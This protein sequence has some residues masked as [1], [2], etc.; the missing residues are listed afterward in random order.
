MPAIEP[1]RALGDADHPGKRL[2]MEDDQLD[3]TIA[4]L[5]RL[6]HG[7]LNLQD[8]E[9]PK[10]DHGMEGARRKLA[11]HGDA[12]APEQ[13]DGEIAMNTDMQRMLE[14]HH[15]QLEQCLK[16]FS[17]MMTHVRTSHASSM[18]AALHPA[19]PSRASPSPAPAALPARRPSTSGPNGLL[20]GNTSH[21]SIFAWNRSHTADKHQLTRHASADGA[22]SKLRPS[23]DRVEVK[24]LLQRSQVSRHVSADNIPANTVPSNPL[25][26]LPP[27]QPQQGDAAKQGKLGLTIESVQGSNSLSVSRPNSPNGTTAGLNENLSLPGGLDKPSLS[28]TE[29]PDASHN[30]QESWVDPGTLNE[31]ERAAALNKV[32]ND[33]ADPDDSRSLTNS[34]SKEKARMS[35]G[36]L[37]FHES[38]RRMSFTGRSGRRNSQAS[39]ASDALTGQAARSEEHHLFNMDIAQVLKSMVAETNSEEEAEARRWKR[40]TRN[41]TRGNLVV[42]MMDHAVHMVQGHHS[43]REQ[44]RPRGNAWAFYGILCGLVIVVDAIIIGVETDYIAADPNGES[45]ITFR[46]L[47]YV[48]NSWYFMEII[49][50]MCQR[51]RWTYFFVGP[52]YLWNWFDMGLIAAAMTDIF[53]EIAFGSGMYIGRV[54][55]TVRLFRAVRVLRLVRWL[56]ILREFQK[57]VLCLAS[58]LQTLLCSMALLAFVMFVFSIFFTQ[59]LP[60]YLESR[61]VDAS[62]ATWSD[63]EIKSAFGSVSKTMVSLF[64]AITAGRNWGEL[65]KMLEEINIFLFVVFLIFVGVAIFGLLNVVAAVFVESAMRATQHYRDLL[66]H[67]KLMRE[68]INVQHLK[69]IFRNIDVDNSGTITLEEMESFLNDDSLKL[70]EYFEALELNASDT[71]SLFLLL[72]RDGSGEVDIDEFCDGCMRLGGNAKSFDINC[73][74][75]EMKRSHKDMLKLVQKMF[76]GLHTLTRVQAST[77]DRM[78]KLARDVTRHIEKTSDAEPE[79]NGERSPRNA[80]SD[81]GGSSPRSRTS[82]I[83]RASRASRATDVMRISRNTEI[84]DVSPFRVSDDGLGSETLHSS[85]LAATGANGT[86]GVTSPSRSSQGPAAGALLRTGSVPMP[87]PTEAQVGMP[88]DQPP[89]LPGV[90]H[91]HAPEASFGR[92]RSVN[93]FSDSSSEGKDG[94]D[95]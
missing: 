31:S 61:V 15:N 47:G 71:V 59:S 89:K 51:E 63:Q 76:L 46:A 3:E 65:A 18:S 8:V 77:K 58:S 32:F 2:S 41:N 88:A 44:P 13:K 14:H 45:N 35:K 73:M 12:A 33:S 81:V 19:T 34:P 52:D 42:R 68:R 43:R 64:Q 69:E 56:Q 84:N 17:R 80:A 67:E 70:Q 28:T 55:R 9:S 16:S 50:R 66:V 93:S 26:P 94:K 53:I 79:D 87:S 1:L 29:V 4:I 36:R 54:F 11:G 91:P 37:S 72:D 82:R 20:A 83:S 38:V 95:V 49:I 75:Y 48:F 85:Q 23:K 6:A 86:G 27:S 40:L 90:L 60:I 74:W 25:V 7:D 57:L 78:H 5:G 10:P 62:R 24:Q 22:T 21:H 30:T 39:A 92:E